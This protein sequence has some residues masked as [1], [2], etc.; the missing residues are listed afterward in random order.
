MDYNKL[1]KDDSIKY[2]R[3]ANPKLK[4]HENLWNGL[5][6][7][8]IEYNIMAKVDNI[9]DK[10]IY[11]AI[12][13][14]AKEQSITDLV[15]ID[16]EFVKSALINELSRIAYENE[17][18]ENRERGFIRIKPNL[19]KPKCTNFDK[20]TESAESFVEW[21]LNNYYSVPEHV[22]CKSSCNK[23]CGECFKKWLQKECE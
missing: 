18:K 23:D 5:P 1:P 22:P 17:E 15:L 14:Y 16:E 20:I 9:A 3:L 6:N 21:V 19:P 13:K 4:Y 8:N 11:D 12:I 10:T 2:V 7:Y